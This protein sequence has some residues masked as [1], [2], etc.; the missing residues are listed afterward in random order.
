LIIYKLDIDFL[1]SVECRKNH[2]AD[3]VLAYF[4]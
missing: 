4:Q 3:E 1:A 2:T